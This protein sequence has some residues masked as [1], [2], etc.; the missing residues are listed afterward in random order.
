MGY[1]LP[2]ILLDITN[3]ASVLWQSLSLLS[4]CS[5]HVTIPC[6]CA[7]R[8]RESDM[9]DIISRVNGTDISSSLAG[10]MHSSSIILTTFQLNCAMGLHFSAFLASGSEPPLSVELSEFS[11][12]LFI[13]CERS[14][15]PSLSNCPR[16][17]YIYI[18][19]YY[20]T[21]VIP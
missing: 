3:N 5:E 7:V 1:A 14:E 16:C 8:M 13:Y 18:Y 10:Y 9:T 21:N 15:P 20:R 17:L 11:L 4:Q 12:Y 19:I 2:G 6:A